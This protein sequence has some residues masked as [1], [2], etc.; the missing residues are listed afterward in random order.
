[1]P[2]KIFIW[3]GHPRAQSL[4]SGLADAYQRGAE[5]EGAVVRRMDVAEM[6]VSLEGFEGYTGK[7]QPLGDDLRAW[8]E[9]LEWC[10]HTVWLHPYWWGG[11]PAKMKAVVDQAMLPGFG[12]KY[13][14]KGALWDKLLTGRTGDVIITSDTPPWFDTLVYGRSGR[15]VLKNQVMG[16]VGIKS[17]KIVQ[18][19]AVKGAKEAKIRRWLQQANRMGQEAG[20]R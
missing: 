19:G 16:F 20:R 6:T 14:D 3:N 18:M 7:R 5:G 2:A 4:C 9:A 12:F 15:K 13:R 11:M 1:M 10:E 8:Q 17:A